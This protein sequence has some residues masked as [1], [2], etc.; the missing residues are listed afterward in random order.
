MGAC[1]AETL[2]QFMSIWVILHTCKLRVYAK[3]IKQITKLHYTNYANVAN[4]TNFI[5]QKLR[6]LRKLRQS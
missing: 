5:I 4:Y 3:I 2:I 6:N 1:F